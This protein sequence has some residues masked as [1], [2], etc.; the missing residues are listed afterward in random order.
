MQK[1][2]VERIKKYVTLDAPFGPPD[3]YQIRDDEVAAHLFDPH[4]KSFNALLRNE[5]SIMIGRRGSGKTALLSSYR[6]NRF[7]AKNS[8]LKSNSAGLDLKRYQI[9]IDVEVHKQFEG[10][11]RLATG[12]SGFARPIETVV[13]DWSDNILDFFLAKL[14]E[15]ASRTGPG[16]KHLVQIGNYLFQ[17][18][19]SPRVRGLAID[20]RDETPRIAARRLIWGETLWHKIRAIFP[21]DR[22]ESSGY[23]SQEVAME[24][25]RFYLDESRKKAL[26]LL[27]SMDEYEV[28]NRL[29]DRTIAALLRFTANFNSTSDQIKIKLGLPSEIV[30]ELRR[31]SANPLKDFV[32]YDLVNWTSTELLQIAAFRYRLFL[33]LY[34]PKIAEQLKQLDFHIRDDVWQF[35]E[36]FF[37]SAHVNHFGKE[38]A[39]IVYIL[40]HTQLLPRQLFMMLQEIVVLNY[41]RHG[42]YGRFLDEEVIEAIEK[43]NGQIAQ[44]IFSAFSH[45]YSGAERVGRAIFAGFPTVFEYKDLET[46]WKRTARNYALH[47]N[48]SDNDMVDLVEMLLRIGIVGLVVDEGNRYVVGN[49]YYNAL[50]PPNI[51]RGTTLCL[52]PIFSRYFKATFN[53]MGKAVL[54]KGIVI[55]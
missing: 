41:A 11:W 25:A 4:S 49:F 28:G 21:S 32:N 46:Q 42:G 40:R 51:A 23:V 35:W 3:A 30:H 7:F 19:E 45:V 2:L 39:V 22:F 17:S 31:A 24:A 13:Q 6:Y 43:M 16:Q 55:D 15:Q 54:P 10:L 8:L 37:S 52:H 9:V 27:D 20:H 34:A 12:H 50:M 48:S 18:E 26:L 29:F 44:E 53:R 38:E 1:P 14:Y 5:I 33:Q 36:S 47:I